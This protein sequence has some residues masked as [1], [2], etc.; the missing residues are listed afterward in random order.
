MIDEEAKWPFSYLQEE[1]SMQRQF[2]SA[3]IGSK[4]EEVGGGQLGEFEK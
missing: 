4:K 1:Y 2:Q 3:N